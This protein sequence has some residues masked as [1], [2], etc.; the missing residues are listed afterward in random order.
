[1][2]PIEVWTSDDT[3]TMVLMPESPD[4]DAPHGVAPQADAHGRQPPAP[5]P[6]H[7]DELRALRTMIESRDQERAAREAQRD[8]Q[9]A[10]MERLV[11]GEDLTPPAATTPAA[12]VRATV[13]GLCQP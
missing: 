5:E 6:T 4:P 1:M 3:G 11:R 10:T 9:L 7:A 2:P 12:P 8:T 13:R